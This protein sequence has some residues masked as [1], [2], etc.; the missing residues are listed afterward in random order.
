M[1]LVFNIPPK[2]IVY[3][4]T[5]LICEVSQHGIAYYFLDIEDKQVKGLSVYQLKS[6]KD[7][8]ANEIKNLFDQQPALSGSFHQVVV[9]YSFPESTLIPDTISGR[10][11]QQQA[12]SILFGPEND[13]Y[14]TLSDASTIKGMT[15]VY[16]V[17][18]SLHRKLINQFPTASFNHQYSCMIRHIALARNLLQVLFYSNKI[19]CCLMGSD[20]LLLINAFDYS[21]KEDVL[22]HLLN[23]RHQFNMPGIELRLNGMIEQ[24]SALYKELHK[25]FLKIKFEDYKGESIPEVKEFPLHY[26]SHLFSIPACA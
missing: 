11:A 25:F 9:S 26:F 22:Y 21:S 3:D 18:K 1:N 4:R 19:I 8:L 14:F 16:R 2:N 7:D 17:A 5:V 12:L 10:E 15:N 13:Q 20:G 24:D 23:I 6:I